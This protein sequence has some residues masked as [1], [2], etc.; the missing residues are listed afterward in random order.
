MIMF[1]TIFYK[2]SMNTSKVK[3]KFTSHSIKKNSNRTN[4]SNNKNL[5]INIINKNRKKTQMKKCNRNNKHIHINNTN[6][7]S[8]YLNTKGINKKT[9]KTTT[10]PLKNSNNTVAPGKNTK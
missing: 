4:N 9:V 2:I 1:K 10:F 8:Y 3:G 5:F 6:K 7:N